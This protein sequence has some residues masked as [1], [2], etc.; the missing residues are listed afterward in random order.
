LERAILLLREPVRLDPGLDRRVMDAIRESPAPSSRTRPVWIAADWLMRGRTL[1]LSPLG[2]LALA[3]GLAGIVLVARSWIAA[4]PTP[5][6]PASPAVSA[7]VPDAGAI[8][9]LIVAPGAQSVSL[10]GDFNDW[11]AGATPMRAVNASGLW[12]AAIPLEPGRYRYAFLLDGARWVADPSR[13]R[14]LEDEFGTPS[15]VVTIGGS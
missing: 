8:Q 9:F 11:D 7:S 12:T 15:S 4:P 13:P 1:R 10:V 2:G 5:G 3:A 14:A 6:A